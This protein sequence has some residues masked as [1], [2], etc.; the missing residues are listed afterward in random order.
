MAMGARNRSLLASFNSFKNDK[1]MIV[2]SMRTRRALEGSSPTLSDR[3]G[4]SA[5]RIVWLGIEN[6]REDQPYI[7]PRNSLLPHGRNSAMSTTVK[8]KLVQG[9]R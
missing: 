1:S 3:R 5:S 7:E 4:F 9:R 6:C 2:L 8:C